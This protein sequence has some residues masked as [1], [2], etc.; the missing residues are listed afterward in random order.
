MCGRPLMDER[1]HEG[2]AA[3]TRRERARRRRLL[4]PVD[5][6]DHTEVSP[7]SSRTIGRLIAQTALLADSALA[8]RAVDRDRPRQRHR[9]GWF[10]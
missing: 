6:S 9:F 2:N 3:Q 5:D 7:A 10:L 1:Q 8:R 4:Q